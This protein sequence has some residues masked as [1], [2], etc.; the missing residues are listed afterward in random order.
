MKNTHY[1]KLRKQAINSWDP[2]IHYPD[3]HESITRN[4]VVLK[5]PFFT[6]VGTG[7]ASIERMI[8]LK[9]NL[10]A[11][12]VPV[13]KPPGFSDELK[14]PFRDMNTVVVRENTEAEFSGLE[15]TVVPGVVESLKIVTREK[16]S[17]IAEYAFDLAK[18]T[19]R[20]KVIA[21]HKANIIKMG[22]GLFLKCCKEVAEKYPDVKYE[23]MIV[24]N[25]SM[26][27]V[28]NPKYFENSV[29]VTTNLYGTIVSNIAVALVG[30]PGCVGGWNEGDDIAVFEQ[31]ARHVAADIAGQGIANPTGLILSAVDMLRHLKMDEHADRIE[32]AV[33]ETYSKNIDKLT[34]DVGG[35]AMTHDF[36]TALMNNMK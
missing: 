14:V 33:R 16:S 1:S 17:Q 11:H 20:T 28:K 12:V 26:Q 27:L 30:G 19:K 9:Y 10:F 8:A 2:E 3:L 32:N 13:H 22:D 34:P 35:K 36:V 24:D 23:E 31:G 4:K 5:G 6:P 7:H 18:R 21:V 25:A 15:H 29:I